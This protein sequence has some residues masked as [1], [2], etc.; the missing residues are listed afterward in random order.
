MFKKPKQ[1]KGAASFRKRPKTTKQDDKDKDSDDNDDDNHGIGNITSDKPKAKGR[2]R[3]RTTSSGEDDSSDNNNGGDGEGG[4]GAG[5]PQESTTELLAQLKHQQSVGAAG[6]GGR[7]LNQF[8]TT[9]SSGKSGGDAT[10]DNS[11][12]NKRRKKVG[13]AQDFAAA[14]TNTLMT[15][16]EMATRGSEYH[17]E[18]ITRN[19]DGKSVT[20]AQASIT[21]G[22]EKAKGGDSANNGTG[23]GTTKLYKGTAK[24]VNKFHAGPLKAPT[25]VRTTCRFDYQPDICKDYKETGFCGFGDTCI[26]LHDRGDTLTGWQL[27]QKYQEQKKKDQQLKEQE[28]N[29]FMDGNGCG[30]GAKGDTAEDTSNTAALSTEDGIPFKCL[31]CR[32]AFD[33]PVVTTCRHYFCTKCIMQSYSGSSNNTPACPVC[34]GDI[35]GGVFNNPTKLYSKMRRIVG[36]DGTFDDY[37][38]AFIK[39]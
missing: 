10:D 30:S 4:A 29:K 16:Q 27:E 6:A 5:G 2:I 34:H 26:Y 31:I 39:D 1:R 20:T 21:G 33:N 11:N 37:A 18:E 38:K 22:D 36:R 17:P 15:A 14:S 28:L 32:N 12:V 23:T 13:M 9:T 3:Q 35:T 8:S 25:F 7:R 19:E 24:V